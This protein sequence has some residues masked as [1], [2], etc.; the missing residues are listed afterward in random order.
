MPW[1]SDF[2]M[3]AIFLNSLG[4]V[5]FPQVYELRYEGRGWGVDG[6]WAG[7]GAGSSKDGQQAALQE[8]YL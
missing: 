3:N 2:I 7:V 1:A 5:A 8:S 6:M 4:F